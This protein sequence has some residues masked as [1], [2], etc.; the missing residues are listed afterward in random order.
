[1][2]CSD[3]CAEEKRWIDYEDEEAQVQLDAADMLLEQIVEETAILLN[4]IDRA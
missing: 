1:M 2:L 3:V 4:D